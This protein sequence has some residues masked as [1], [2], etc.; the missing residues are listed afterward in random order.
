MTDANTKKI[1]ESTFDEVAR[2]YD[3]NLFFAITA[4]NMA[5][6]FDSKKDFLLLDISTGTG[7]VAFEII[8]QHPNIN[9]EDCQEKSKKFK[10]R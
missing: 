1:I 8:K 9:I 6:G 2:K 3:S 10:Y 5:N 4:K 7:I